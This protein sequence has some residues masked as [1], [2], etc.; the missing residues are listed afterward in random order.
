MPSPQP[1]KWLCLQRP[2]K[3]R[4]ALWWPCAVTTALAKSAPSWHLPVAVASSV[5][6]V[7]AVAM[8]V[9]RTGVTAAVDPMTV[10]VI[11]PSVRTAAPV[12]ATRLSVPNA[13]RSSTPK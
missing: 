7:K 13:M 11:A 10:S 12:W 2:S 3:H 5:I 1:L 4:P 6:A 8:D 9:L